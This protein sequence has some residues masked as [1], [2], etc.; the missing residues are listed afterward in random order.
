MTKLQKRKEL[1]R[2]EKDNLR[3]KKL[4]EVRKGKGAGRPFKPSLH[5]TRDQL[6]TL[7]QQ[8]MDRVRNNMNMMGADYE[9]AS[10]YAIF[11]RPEYG[12]ENKKKM[13]MIKPKKKKN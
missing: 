1:T 3:R 9:I 13:I 11:S 5:N 8:E 7:R 12:P 6:N 2:K 10:R 4:V